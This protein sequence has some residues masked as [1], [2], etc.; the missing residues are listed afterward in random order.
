MAVTCPYCGIHFPKSDFINSRHKVTCA[1]WV[2]NGRSTKPLPCLCGHE[3]TSLTQM[4]RHRSQC[5]AWKNRDRGEI[6]MARL[7]DTLQRNHGSGATNPRKIPEAEEKRKSTLLDRYGAENV[8]C[9]ESS[10]FD[11]VQDSLDGKRP[12]LK[13]SANPFAWTEVQEKIRRVNLER[14]GFENPQQ[15]PEIRDRTRSTCL[16]RYGGELCASP[17]LLAKIEA[18]NLTR[19]GFKKASKSPEVKERARQTNLARWGVEWTSQNPE[20][21]ARQAKTQLETYGSYYFVSEEGRAAIRATLQQRYGVSHPS[22]IEGFWE[23]TV[24]TFVR[25]YGATHPLLLVEFLEKRRATCQAKY[26]V[27]SPLQ[28]PEVYARLSA[29]VQDRYGVSCV[30]QAE[31]VKEKARQTN[32]ANYGVPCVLQ[33]EEVKEKVRQTNIANYGVPYAM[34]AEEVREKVRQTNIANY[35][36][37]YA[38]QAEEVKEKARQTNIA[39]Y[40]VPHPMMN[41][42]Y[43]KAQLEKIRRPGP[44][45]PER[46]L[47]AMAPELLY[48]GTGD[49]WRWLPLLGHHKNPDFILPGSDPEHPKK[50]VTKVVELF[51]NFW[52]SRM[53]TGK[54]NFEHE[55]ELVKAFEEVGIACLVV[56]ESE[57][58]HNPDETKARVLNFIYST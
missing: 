30:F 10:I 50:G 20:V 27:D 45:L 18:T 38:I 53:F 1:G 7:A 23:K 57:V 48:T 52:H 36:V 17:I 4:K 39:N 25:R 41:R 9:R 24:A 16:S 5:P 56:W 28:S 13:G 21:Q 32:I 37:P 40:G 11:K 58:K 55:S 51:G 34:Q 35:G 31:E 3:S 8:F 33:A 42:E 54:A 44:N 47:Q 14:Y 26:G 2:A 12:I 22:Q 46:L 6:Q 19:Y 29:T 49:F 43:A 15:A